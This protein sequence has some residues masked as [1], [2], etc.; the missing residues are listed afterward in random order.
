[1]TKKRPDDVLLANRG[2]ILTQ[3]Q[4]RRFESSR[5]QTDSYKEVIDYVNRFHAV[6]GRQNE[7]LGVLF[8]VLNK[9]YDVFSFWCAENNITDAPLARELMRLAWRDGFDKGVL[10]ANRSR[11]NR[12]GTTK[13]QRDALILN[14]WT[15]H[16]AAGRSRGYAAEKIAND[17]GLSEKT[18]RDFLKGK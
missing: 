13:A 15:K 3:E 9:H 5:H 8:A 16:K 2:K 18:V 17:V 4:W 7:L 1:M 11:G 12:G 10:A 14:A 6:K